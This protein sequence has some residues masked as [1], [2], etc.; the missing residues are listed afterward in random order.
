MTTAPHNT[1]NCSKLL[2]C[3]ELRRS[4]APPA[5]TTARVG[6]QSNASET[7][8]QLRSMAD[9]YQSI[10]IGGGALSHG[11][12]DLVDGGGEELP[13]V[14]SMGGQ[15][16]GARGSGHVSAARRTA[17]PGAQAPAQDLERRF[18]STPTS[19]PSAAHQPSL[20]GPP[21]RGVGRS[22]VNA[23]T[24]STRAKAASTPR[25]PASG[26]YRV[27]PVQESPKVK[28]AAASVARRVAGRP[29]RHAAAASS[30]G[31][32]AATAAASAAPGP[33]RGSPK[34]L[35]QQRFNR[36]VADP[37]A[38][39]K[40]SRRAS[41][42]VEAYSAGFPARLAH[43]G[44][45]TKPA[46]RWDKSVLSVDMAHLL[47]LCAGGLVETSH[48]YAFVARQAFLELVAARPAEV[49]ALLP[50]LTRPLRAALGSRVDGVF[51]GALSCLV[52]L[53][54]ATGPALTEHLPGLL[55]PLSGRM[56]KAKWKDAVT[57]ALQTLEQNGGPDATTAIKKKIPTY[58]SIFF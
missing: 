42:F 24:A 28:A 55:S 30:G 15:Y 41:P 25:R 22:V 7:L 46:L 53:S 54:T 38:A 29:G 44:A 21:R 1:P 52:A 17:A 51:A 8:T 16:R 31:A 10:R 47:P 50:L 48:P 12:P 36:K 33:G 57:S 27:S 20:G 26:R 5:H 32:G 39:G 9:S 23:T 11:R 2:A 6:Q 37:F 14:F 19:S 35:S 34:R 49:P 56:L 43:T 58:M 45:Q 13:G 4:C 18:R 40:G 3:Q